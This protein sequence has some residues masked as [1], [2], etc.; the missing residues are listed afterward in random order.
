MFSSLSRLGVPW[1]LP[2]RQQWLLLE[3]VHAEA[4]IYTFVTVF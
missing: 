4:A 2:Q 1:L 3:K